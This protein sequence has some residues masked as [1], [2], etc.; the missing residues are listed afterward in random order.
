MPHVASFRDPRG[1]GFMKLWNP[2]GSRP[3]G[4]PGSL[5]IGTVVVTT[6]VDSHRATL[7]DFDLSWER[8]REAYLDG[9]DTDRRLMEL[10]RTDNGFVMS[11]T[12]MQAPDCPHGPYWFWPKWR[13]GWYINWKKG[14]AETKGTNWWMQYLACF[15]DSYIQPTKYLQNN[16]LP[17]VLTLGV[18]GDENWLRGFLGDWVVTG[19]W[20]NSWATARHFV[21]AALRSGRYRSCGVFDTEYEAVV[22]LLHFKSWYPAWQKDAKSGYVARFPSARPAIDWSL[23]MW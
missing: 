16:A 18:L 6:P 8:I 13:A 10:K 7:A 11:T 19:R 21:K 22:V 17:R 15:V 23:D 2:R 1:V 9:V 3:Q 5:W 14:E 12:L 4:S 20:G